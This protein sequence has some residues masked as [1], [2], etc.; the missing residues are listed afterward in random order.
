MIIARNLFGLALSR[1]EESGE[2]WL[3]FAPQTKIENRKE[4]RAGINLSTIMSERGPIV[5]GVLEDWCREIT[6]DPG[7]MESIVDF[8][9]GIIDGTECI[10]SDGLA[11]N[12]AKEE[13][14]KHC[15]FLNGTHGKVR[16]MTC[17]RGQLEYLKNRLLE[18][19]EKQRTLFPLED[20]ELR[21]VEFKVS[22]LRDQGFWTPPLDTAET[23][24]MRFYDAMCD[25]AV[26]IVLVDDVGMAFR[27]RSALEK[28]IQARDGK[29]VRWELREEGETTNPMASPSSSENKEKHDVEN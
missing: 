22:W 10:D 21:T 16:C 17:V 24:L 29:F 13:G 8:L 6:E 18:K 3:V 19:E 5:S 26:E 20:P 15:L 12:F 1:E 4:R 25:P 11:K 27:F 14:T 28:W 9:D 7:R 2:F 23:G